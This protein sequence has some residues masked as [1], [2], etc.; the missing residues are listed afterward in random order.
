VAIGQTRGATGFKHNDRHRPAGKGYDAHIA[1][2]LDDEM[3][4]K[5][6]AVFLRWNAP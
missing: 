5:S 2:D 6:S 1:F 3:G 4:K